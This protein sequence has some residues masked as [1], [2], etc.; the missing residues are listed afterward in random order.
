[1]TEEVDLVGLLNKADTKK[2]DD[3]LGTVE[4]YAATL[5]R[6]GTIVDKLQKNNVLPSIVRILGFKAG[7]GDVNAN[8]LQTQAASSSHHMLY[9]ELNKL[10]EEQIKDMLTQGLEQQKKSKKK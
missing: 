2:V 10:S 4:K 1:M 8:P 9:G 7:A 3:L 6:V 5:D